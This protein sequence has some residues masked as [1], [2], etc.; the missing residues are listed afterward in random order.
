MPNR[1]RTRTRGAFINSPILF[2]GYERWHDCS[3]PNWV[4]Y[5]NES[6]CKVGVVETMSDYVDSQFRR[7]QVHGEIVMNPLVHST[8]KVSMITGDG[9]WIKRLGGI[10]CGGSTQYTENRQDGPGFIALVNWREAVIPGLPLIPYARLISYS[11]IAELESEVSTKCL[12][13]RGNSANNLFESIAEIRQT[14][15]M[16][17]NPL[18]NLWRFFAKNEKAI[19]RVDNVA[20]AWLQYRYGVKPL[21]NDVAGILAGMEKKIGMMRVTTR[22]RGHISRSEIGANT[23][24]EPGAYIATYGIQKTDNVTVRA[25]SLDEYVVDRAQNIGFSTKGLITVPWELT[26][27]SFVADWFVNFGDYLKALVPLP[28]LKQLGSVITTYRA[29]ETI[30]TP[31]SFFGDG[32]Y[33]V[34]RNPSGSVSSSEITKVRNSLRPPKLVVRTDFRFDDA[35][36]LADSASL[37]LQKMNSLFKARR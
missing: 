17:R 24:I 34:I 30:Y 12:A 5:V 20:S 15:T 33:A 19:R 8:R 26:P 28:S 1:Q 10:I 16:L 29:A 35:I 36:R 14:L 3:Q 11:D 4:Q 7:K 2:Q 9:F 18:A 32:D 37:L 6:P 25:M 22:S 31:S 13:E 27:Y 23:Y 21:I